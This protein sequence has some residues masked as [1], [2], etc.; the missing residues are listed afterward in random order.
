MLWDQ[1]MHEYVH[2]AKF[3]DLMNS[4]VEP[5]KR[6]NALKRAFNAI[7]THTMLILHEPVLLYCTLFLIIIYSAFGFNTSQVSVVWQ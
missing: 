4:V 1:K 6:P 2:F 3:G 7:Q 5:K